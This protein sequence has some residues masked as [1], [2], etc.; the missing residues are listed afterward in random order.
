MVGFGLVM[1]GLVM[2]WLWLVLV[3]RVVSLVIGFAGW[4]LAGRS[5]NADQDDQIRRSKWARP[6]Y[7]THL[8]GNRAGHLRGVLTFEPT[9]LYRAGSP[10]DRN[11]ESEWAATPVHAVA[12]SGCAAL[13]RGRADP[14]CAAA[15]AGTGVGGGQRAVDGGH[16]GHGHDRAHAVW[17]ADGGTEELQPQEQRQEELS[18]DSDV[19]SGDAGIR[20]RRVAQRRPAHGQRGGGTSAPGLRSAAGVREADLRAG[21]FRVLLLERCGHLCGTRLPIRHRGA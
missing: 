17:Q 9:P 14:E 12:V 18:A 1:V 4:I 21:G 10:A 8:H 13:E 20:G 15:D 19:S 2:V 11:P 6:E 16:S 7:R 5:L 3:W